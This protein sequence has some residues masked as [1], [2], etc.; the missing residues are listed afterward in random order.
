MAGGPAFGNSAMN[1]YLWGG[2]NMC[3]V[4]KIYLLATNGLLWTGIG[5][6]ISVKGVVNYL[7]AAPGKLWWMIPLSL[8]VFAAFF[9]MFT[10]IVRKYSDR[11]ML[12][13]GRRSPSTRLL[14]SRGIS[15][16]L[17]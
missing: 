4:R 2:S 17:S 11:I 14:A 15:S 10:G 12:C 13:P 1:G 7:R 8:L 3:K 5:T 9:L 16:S 6:R